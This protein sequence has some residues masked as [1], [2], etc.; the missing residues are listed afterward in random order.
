[1]I[2]SGRLN[3]LTALVLSLMIVPAL[4][5]FM[6]PAS[7]AVVSA[8]D[9]LSVKRSYYADISPDGNWIAYTLSVPRDAN[10]EA[11]GAYSELYLVSTRT[12]EILPFITGKVNIGSPLFSPDGR[13]V[14]FT[15]SRGEKAKTQVWMIPVNGGEAVQVTDSKTGA[16]TFRWLP[17][18]SGVAWLEMEPE[19]EIEKTLDKMGYGF[20]YYEENIRNRELYIGRFGAP[21]EK[22]KGEKVTEGIHVVDFEI[23]PDGKLAAISSCPLNLIDQIYMFKKIFIVELATGRT[24]RLTDN[25][26]KLGTFA[27]SPDGRKLAYVAALTQSDHAVSQAYVVDVA[28][29]M[30]LS[31]TPENFRGHI[32]WVGWENSGTVCYLAGEG[33]WNTLSTVPARGGKRKVILDSEKTGIVF[34]APHYTK[35]FRDFAFTASSPDIPGDVFYWKKGDKEL[36]RLT[37]FNP[38]IA[39]RELGRQEVV[40]YKAR[41]DLDIEGILVY[42][43]GY[44]EGKRYPLIVTVH[45]GPESHYSNTWLGSYFHPAQALAGKGYVVFYP[46]YRASTGYGV[47]FAAQGYEDAAGREFDDC[48]DAIDFLV[49]KGIADGSRVGLGGGSYGGFAAAWFASYYTDKVRAVCMFVGISD[50]I[51]KRGTTDIPYEEL[52]VHSGRKL[53]ADWDQWE[54]SLKRSPIFWAHQSKTAVLIIGGAADTR[55]DPSQSLEFHRRL[56]MNGHPA[57]R[58]VQYPGEGHGNRKQPGRIDVL[59]RHMQWY[60]WYVRDKNPLD[61]PMPPLMI[62]E[63][64][65]LDLGEDTKDEEGGE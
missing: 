48:A 41:D 10:E 11:G 4:S 52:Y 42:P 35:D 56:K 53:D 13:K 19:P 46:N 47:E 33:V 12:G 22:V 39:E 2:R 23:S 62:Y 14:G 15:M 37:T 43:V 1:M 29:S 25:P 16:G 32:S 31:L 51:S 50:L 45:G 36:R 7:A 40:T 64:Y 63:S 9:M 26:G 58:L 57:V 8:E 6:A 18:G 28:G 59:Y 61:G 44:E 38:W 27:F 3:F 49:E 24:R 54:F 55:V 65:G 30:P 20:I 60:D 5:A 34:G 21:G 17:D